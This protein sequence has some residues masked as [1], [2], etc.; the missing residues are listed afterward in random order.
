[1]TDPR[2]AVA[3]VVESY[4]GSTETFIHDLLT[5]LRGVRPVIVARRV[6]DRDRFPVPAGATLHL[7]P[8]PRG[9][10]AWAANAVRR[11][12]EGF[13]GH[14]DDL[15]RDEGVGVVHAHFGPMASE[16]VGVRRRTGL[17]LVTSFYGYDASIR[18]VVEEYRERYRAL[19]DTGSVFLVEGS[20]MRRRLTEIGCPPERIRILRIGIDPRRYPFAERRAPGDGPIVVLLCGRMVPKKGHPDALEALAAARRSVPRLVL[21]IVGD[22]PDRPTV[23]ATIARL[24]LGDAVTLLGATGRDAFLAEL[25]RAHLYL[26]PSRTAPD[27]DTEGGAPTTLL[28]AQA[29]GLP[30]V[31]TRHADIPEVVRPDESARLVAEGDPAALGEALASLAAAPA[32]WGAMGRAGRAH[33]EASHDVA[34]LASD[35]ESLYARLVSAGAACVARSGP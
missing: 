25:S 29:C 11:R 33:I 14:L 18:S 31:A 12:I 30:I 8:P 34:L 3:H 26:Q 20:A 7:S 24:G 9:T 10:L 27:G 5:A 28:E 4:L 1:M 35:L 21:R 17:P 23:E 15:L 19:F 13:D 22:G 2:P 32:T 16:L 6:V